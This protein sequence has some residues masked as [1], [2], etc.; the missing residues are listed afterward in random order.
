MELLLCVFVVWGMITL[1]GQTAPAVRL[2][3]QSHGGS[4]PRRFQETQQF[5]LD[6]SL[7]AY[8]S[9]EAEGWWF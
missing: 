8:L 6:S 1:S 5:V 9:F 4:P 7:M 3:L 2:R